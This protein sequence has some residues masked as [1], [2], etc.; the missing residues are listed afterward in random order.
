[1]TISESIDLIEREGSRLAKSVPVEGMP[2]MVFNSSVSREGITPTELAAIHASCPSDLAE[3]WC[4]TRSAKLFV[5]QVY[6]QWG[7]EILDPE[8][9]IKATGE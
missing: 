2:D 8:E 5:D 9:A 3:F 1:M 6:G 4:K 7:L